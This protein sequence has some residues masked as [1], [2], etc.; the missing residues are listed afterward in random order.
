MFE[1][2]VS[3]NVF[4]KTKS[5]SLSLFFVL[6]GTLVLVM[7]NIFY[8]YIDQNG[9]LQESYF[10]PM[11]SASFLLG[12]MGLVVSIIWFY[13]KRLNKPSTPPPID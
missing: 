11:G 1:K 6:L 9:F 8:G 5:V 10:L 3:I 7:E 12:V 4:I 13:L 2:V